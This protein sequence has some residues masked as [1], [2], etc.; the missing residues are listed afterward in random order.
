MGKTCYD[1]NIQVALLQVYDIT[2]KQ[3]GL[4][5]VYF[6]QHWCLLFCRWP[7][8]AWTWP[9]L[10]VR[11]W[12]CWATME[13][14]SQQQSTCALGSKACTLGLSHVRNVS[15]LNHSQNIS[16][17]TKYWCALSRFVQKSLCHLNGASPEA[18]WNGGAQFWRCHRCWTSLE[19]QHPGDGE[20]RCNSV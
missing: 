18:H 7:W 8:K 17:S 19:Q 14:A 1:E 3:N 13:L 2:N 16:P 6:L 5:T 12:L 20:T 15:W 11:F 10:K 4:A 9:C